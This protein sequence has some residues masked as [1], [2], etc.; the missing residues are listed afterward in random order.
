MTAAF[1]IP[2]KTDAH[3]SRARRVTYYI[4]HAD[5]ASAERRICRCL[6]HSAHHMTAASPI[7]RVLRE[8]ERATDE[9]VRFTSDLIRVP[10]VNPPG[11]FYEDC[12]RLIGDHLERLEHD[13]EYFAA[14]GRPEHTPRYPRLNVVGTRRGQ[15]ADSVLAAWRR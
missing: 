5:G 3:I 10:T 11:E 4:E 7:D 15:L 9:V 14:E 1:P 8:V 12:A 6:L 13:V 2:S